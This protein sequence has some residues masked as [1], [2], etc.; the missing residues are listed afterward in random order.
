MVLLTPDKRMQLEEAKFEV[1][2]NELLSSSRLPKKKARA[3]AAN[4]KELCEELFENLRNIDL[5]VQ[6]AKEAKKLKAEIKV[7]KAS[8]VLAQN[9]LPWD[10]NFC[11][12]DVGI[13]LFYQCFR[14]EIE[15]FALLQPAGSAEQQQEQQKQRYVASKLV[16]IFKK[17]D[18]QKT[19]KTRL[20]KKDVRGKLLFSTE[21][22]RREERGKKKKS[23]KS[24]LTE[25][26]EDLIEI[27]NKID[28]ITHYEDWSVG[29]SNTIDEFI[30]C[31]FRLFG[32]SKPPSRYVTNSCGCLEED[33]ERDTFHEILGIP[34]EACELWTKN[35]VCKGC[36]KNQTSK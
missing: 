35:K 24:L 20:K 14:T 21:E 11:W 29:D 22:E 1:K 9:I 30:G 12:I 15:N 36:K 8:E 4:V 25:F 31:V 18:E 16:Q 28:P 17:M 3:F 7:E 23:C 33:Y 26:R 32:L 34:K 19:K 5:S 10:R 6:K 13:M 27:V 2:L